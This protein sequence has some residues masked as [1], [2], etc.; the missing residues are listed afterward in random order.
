MDLS[1]IRENEPNQDQPTDQTFDRITETDDLTLE[2]TEQTEADSEQIAQQCEPEIDADAAEPEQPEIIEDAPTPMPMISKT[3]RMAIGIICSALPIVAGVIAAIIALGCDINTKY[4]TKPSDVA[5]TV[6][7]AAAVLIPLICAIFLSR[8]NVGNSVSRTS[9][10]SLLPL[11]ASV[12]LAYH[13]LMNDLG[14]WGDAILLLSIAAAVFFILQM[15]NSKEVFKIL[16]AIGVFALGTAI[17]GLLYLDFEI[18]LNS[19]F[20]LAAQFGGVAL[21]LG[22][23]ADARATLDRINA[24]WFISLKSVASS[25]CL[26]CAGLTFTV[27]ARGFNLFPEIYLVLSVFYACY[28]VNSIAEIISISLSLP[29]SDVE[30]NT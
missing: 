25:L 8:K 4:L 2:T 24:A 17:I 20:K 26:I 16:C 12:Y 15:L 6:T 19:P 13:T 9:W 30:I 3:A 14:K 21:I 18:E 10:G 1:E 7:A 22:T 29:N 28:A 5:L 11:A 23:I 27:F